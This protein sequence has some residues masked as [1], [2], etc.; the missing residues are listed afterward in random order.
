M[1]YDMYYSAIKIE[2]H[3]AVCDKLDE[4]WGH[5]AN[6]NKPDG[7]R[8]EKTRS[9]CEV[10]A[11]LTDLPV[12]VTARMNADQIISLYTLHVHKIICQFYLDKAGKKIL[13][14][15]F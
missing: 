9:L 5:Y 6:W 4:P 10:M 2:G 15:F 12:V 7:E 13:K 11:V 8:Q 3:P 1:I 14:F